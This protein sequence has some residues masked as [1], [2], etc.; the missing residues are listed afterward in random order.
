VP[1]TVI[2]T[3][4]LNNKEKNRLQYGLK[5]TIAFTIVALVLITIILNIARL[6]TSISSLIFV[7][8]CAIFIGILAYINYGIITDLIKNEKEIICATVESKTYLS[9]SKRNF[10]R[11]QPFYLITLNKKSYSL[12]PKHYYSL[13]VGDVI[14]LNWAPNAKYDLSIKVVEKAVQKNENHVIKNYILNS[15]TVPLDK[16][17]I[18]KIKRNKLQVIAFYI[19]FGTIPLFIFL[20]ALTTGLSL[21]F[22]WIGVAFSPALLF[23]RHA[24]KKIIWQKTNT[25]KILDIGNKNINDYLITD[26][27]TSTQFGR[28]E[29]ILF[30]NK[31]KFPVTKQVFKAKSINDTVTIST[32]PITNW[33]LNTY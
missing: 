19:A 13:N 4:P 10:S 15:K 18:A 31:K 6:D 30:S 5:A 28:K 20:I 23:T 29:Y 8:F 25:S 14:E 32:T 12:Q 22:W 24:Y 33:I 16:S 27:Q 17:D 21:G 1:Q 26:K 2:T 9:G 3:S 11:K 7:T